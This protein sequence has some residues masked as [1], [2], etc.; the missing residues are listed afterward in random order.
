M[1]WDLQSA[2]PGGQC[3][4]SKLQGPS[5]S[6]RGARGGGVAE[7]LSPQPSPRALRGL[8]PLPNCLPSPMS[9]AGRLMA[10]WGAEGKSLAPTGRHS[11]FV[12]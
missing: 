12:Q 6:Q 9:D 7:L 1:K 8:W 11:D 3:V 4:P 10:S 2:S 5:L